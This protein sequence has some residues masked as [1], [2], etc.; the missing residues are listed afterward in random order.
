VS[1][2]GA[3][4]EIIVAAS[5]GEVLSTLVFPQTFEL[6]ILLWQSAFTEHACPAAQLAQEPPQ[7]MSVS[8]PPL[9]PSVQ[10]LAVHV[11]VPSQ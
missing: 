11:P 6:Q 4:G 2:I 10:L 8:V 7:S 5:T 9:K 3:S 1:T